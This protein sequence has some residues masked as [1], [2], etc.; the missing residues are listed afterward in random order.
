MCTYNVVLSLKRICSGAVALLACGVADAAHEV[1]KDGKG[2]GWVA[3]ASNEGEQ[4]LQKFRIAPGLKVNMWAAEPMLANPVAL[5][6]D[7]KGRAY[8][9]ETFRID[10]Q[11][12]LDIR[13]YGN[14]LDDDLACRTVDD[15]AAVI[16]K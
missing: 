16:R 12:V 14:W 3:P 9:A 6:F 7:E 4:A 15:R 13:G 11:G 2:T 1:S 8:V 5:C 10:S